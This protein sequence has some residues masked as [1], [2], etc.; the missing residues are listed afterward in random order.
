MGF[1]AEFMG[2]DFGDGQAE[3]IAARQSC[4][5]FNFSFLA[6]A[7]LEGSGALQT[8]A[9][10]TRRR[11]SDMKIGEI[12]YALHCTPAGHA[13]SDLT[14]W[15]ISDAAYEVFSGM[16]S[17]IDALLASPEDGVVT[18]IPGSVVLAVQGPQALAALSKVTDVGADAIAKLRYFECCDAVISGYECSIGR[19][20][21]T[22]EAGFEIISS[23]TNS[24][25]ALWQALSRVARP[26]GYQAAEILRIEAGFPLFM[27]EFLVQVFP[28]ELGLAKYG[29]AVDRHDRLKLVCFRAA[30]L[31]PDQLWTP[32]P[33]L[34]RPSKEGEITVTSACY[35]PQ[36]QAT[37]G[38]GFI[39]ANTPESR[40]PPRDI[41]GEFELLSLETLPF[42]DPQKLRPR[43]PW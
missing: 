11:L 12:R 4:C 5:V 20:G 38:L 15:R 10:L 18:N 2:R 33:E 43:L 31:Q 3:A 27:Q 13:V 22:G 14:I 32:E 23:D 30:G 25:Q 1:N 17:D 7:R 9:R 35:S 36:A 24:Q 29:D 21:Y 42:Y 34:Q 8:M 26:A 16:Q 40:T 39:L 41:Q 37:L 6:R 28:S 19:L